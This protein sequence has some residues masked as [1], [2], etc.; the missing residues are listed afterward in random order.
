MFQFIFI[1]FSNRTK[2]WTIM[3]RVSESWFGSYLFG[4]LPETFRKFEGSLAPVQWIWEQSN[5]INSLWHE[6]VKYFSI[7]G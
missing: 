4:L 1:H 7:C 6:A 2:N 3:N 5:Q